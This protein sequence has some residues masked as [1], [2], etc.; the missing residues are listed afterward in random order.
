M[1]QPYTFFIILLL[2]FG[3]FV[4]GYWRYDIVACIALFI[5]ILV[6][7]VPYNQAFVG[8]S[9]PAVITVACVMIITQ[10]INRSGTVDYMVSK[11]TPIT[12]NAVL[13]ITSL[14]VLTGLLSAFMNNVGALALMM[15]VAIQ[16]AIKSKRSPSL[17][18]MPIV[19]SFAEIV[20]VRLLS[21]IINISLDEQF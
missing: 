6:G 15:P 4:W 19:G 3:L 17:V 16:T 21:P 11:L 8:F 13:H 12:T 18:L 7:V 5:S 10:A 9:N 1:Y 20:V 2:T 14:T